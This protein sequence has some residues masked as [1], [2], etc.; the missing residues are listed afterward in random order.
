MAT[1]S[2]AFT[3]VHEELAYYKSG[4]EQLE[5]DLQDFQQSS[6]ELELELEKDVEASEKRERDLGDKL[7]AL[8]YQV[9]EWRTRYNQSR[10]ESNAAQS[11]LQKEIT[12]LREANRIMQ[13]KLR[14]MEVANDEYEVQARNTTTSLDDLESKY[15]QVSERNVLLEEEVKS[16]EH[17]RETLRIETQRL[18][19]E[20]SD[21]NVEY[22]ITM[23]KLRAA[24]TMNEGRPQQMSRLSESNKKRLSSTHSDRSAVTDSTTTRRSLN[25]AMSEPS[26]SEPRTPSSLPYSD[27]SG[28]S[29]VPSS[30]IV[31]DRTAPHHDDTPRPEHVMQKK[32][33]S[34]PSAAPT[35]RTRPS[36]VPRDGFCAS[37]QGGVERLAR[38]NS[39]YHIRGLMGEMRKLEERLQTA[40]TRLAPSQTQEQPVSQAVSEHQHEPSLPPTITMRSPSKRR[41]VLPATYTPPGQVP[42]SKRYI[43]VSDSPRP[44]VPAKDHMPTLRSNVHHENTSQEQ[45]ST[46]S[47]P[48]AVPPLRQQPRMSMASSGPDAVPAVR[49]SAYR[50]STNTSTATLRRV[51]GSRP[52]MGHMSNSDATSQV[53]SRG[54][55]G[56]G[57]NPNVTDNTSSKTS[58]TPKATGRASMSGR[59][60]ASNLRNS[61]A[62]TT[63]SA[64]TLGRRSNIARPSL[65]PPEQRRFATTT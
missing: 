42:G 33:R 11:T 2:R 40:K 23:E 59:P 51:M 32:L 17:E 22:E 46:V 58:I 45:S 53:S 30:R 36:I 24:Q 54:Q 18:R 7:D 65:A 10:T 13:M 20:L 35:R 6:R 50:P 8:T 31:I 61:P 29:R 64:G 43:L 41:S 3:T 55:P 49:G 27:A 56:V 52:S 60:S 63:T 38:T 15:N 57:T 44:P 14:D 5:A 26:A 47:S 16:G 1:S 19:D 25:T 9:K 39:L 48:I 28:Q 37:E 4:Y 34:R 21:L 12:S 62:K